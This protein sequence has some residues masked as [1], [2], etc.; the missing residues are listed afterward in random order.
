MVTVNGQWLSDP[1]VAYADQ[2][3]G[4][5]L[6]NGHYWYDANTGL[7]G[8]QGGPAIGRVVGPG[9]GVDAVV[10]NLRHRSSIRM[11]VAKAVAA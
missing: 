9:R 2:V 6:P 4:F 11:G 5:P 8:V 7:W 3:A 10:P 1:A